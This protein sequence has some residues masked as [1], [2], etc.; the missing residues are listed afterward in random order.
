MDG[1]VHQGRG[2]KT[3]KRTGVSSDSDADES[4]VEADGPLTAS[5]KLSIGIAGKRLKYGTVVVAPPEPV[6]ARKAPKRRLTWTGI[7]S[8][9]QRQGPAII[10]WE[11]NPWADTQTG[12]AQQIEAIEHFLEPTRA[13]SSAYLGWRARDRGDSSGSSM[14][15]VEEEGADLSMDDIGL[16]QNIQPPV[17]AP[18]DRQFLLEPS[19]AL[20]PIT[21]QEPPTQPVVPPAARVELTHRPSTSDGRSTNAD[22]RGPSPDLPPFD[23]IWLASRKPGPERGSLSPAAVASGGRQ[24]KQANVLKGP[25]QEA[26]PA[27][28]SASRHHLPNQHGNDSDDDDSDDESE[29]AEVESELMEDGVHQNTRRDARA[30]SSKV[31]YATKDDV[32]ALTA[33]FD[34]GI[35]E[36]RTLFMDARIKE[37]K[38]NRASPSGAANDD[39]PDTEVDDPIVVEKPARPRQRHTTDGFLRAKTVTKHRSYGT[40]SLQEI[41][42]TTVRELLG[43]EDQHSPFS[44]VPTREQMELYED[45]GEH[46]PAVPGFMVDVVGTPSSFWNK[47]ATDVFTEYV[48]DNGLYPEKLRAKVRAAFATHL[49]AV[50]A[51][52]TKIHGGGVHKPSEK[53]AEKVRRSLRRA[54]TAR[55]RLDVCETFP[56]LH[57]FV[58]AMEAM[59]E[60]GHSGD[61]SDHAGGNRQFAI[62]NQDWRAAQLRTWVRVLDLLHISLRFKEDGSASR[63]SWPRIRKPS[64]RSTKGVAVTGLPENFYNAEW[65]AKLTERWRAVLDVQPA[66][67]LDIPHALLL[68]AARYMSVTKPEDKPL[69]KEKVSIDELQHWLLTGQILQGRN[70]RGGRR[71]GL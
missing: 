15:S 61:E 37:L 18:L 41:I 48:I 29:E 65:L 20:L 50:K 7:P 42:R 62:V 45:T 70:G 16:S 51:Q 44:R 22:S 71:T 52:Y 26:S 66:I 63:G 21:P 59:G 57:T 30:R 53:H 5:G 35:S 47:V 19:P 31:E 39:E 40:I 68:Y 14:S 64:I 67:S 32:R 6:P 10:P 46:G 56:G 60:E 23:F 34:S 36:L 27:Q 17:S 11:S 8:G 12:S 1:P 4:D 2:S 13:P 54:T 24:P 55:W 69:P 33:A 25:T 58:P 28:P 49:K 43:H 38:E 3:K 9:G